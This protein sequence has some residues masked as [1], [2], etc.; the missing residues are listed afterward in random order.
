VV[1]QEVTVTERTQTASEVQATLDAALAA[2]IDEH[3]KTP[4]TKA[5]ALIK[6]GIYR[7]D[8]SKQAPL[9]ANI[10][11]EMSD[12]VMTQWFA[13]G[14]GEL[15]RL[16]FN[17][18][19]G[20]EEIPL[21]KAAPIPEPELALAKAVDDQPDGPRRAHVVQKIGIY[22]RD[23]AN[24]VNQSVEQPQERRDA[25]IKAW[26][27][28]DPGEMQLKKNVLDAE[29]TRTGRKIYGEGV[30]ADQVVEG[31]HGKSSTDVG[32]GIGDSKS[33]AD[34]SIARSL[35]KAPKGTLGVMNMPGQASAST[36]NPGSGSD[37][38]G[39]GAIK[40]TIVR[41]KT[42]TGGLGSVAGSDTAGRRM[43]TQ[44]DDKSDVG[45]RKAD[46]KKGRSR[47]MGMD[48][49]ERA[50]ELLKIASDDFMA[51]LEAIQDEDQQAVVAEVAGAHCADLAEF[52]A[53]RAI[54]LQKRDMDQAIAEWLGEDPD[55]IPMK[56]FVAEALGTAEEIPLE[57]AKAIMEWEPPK[58]APSFRVRR[59]A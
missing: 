16:I 34:Q 9:L 29:M 44:Q 33:G 51:A 42:T 26:L 35:P 40:P 14:D 46:A 24:L 18:A 52:S 19:A 50:T 39:G 28:V 32:S 13:E 37:D 11:D 53:Q 47:W 7:Q 57:M 55:A 25:L 38:T 20:G 12:A 3:Y 30:K 54:T 2:Y 43:T 45:R 10:D 17:A 36:A 23:L 56:K 27:E 48:K 8:L 41:R 22:T 1:K 15:K 31:S 5:G 58:A 21:A 6:I 4:E 59:A 49:I